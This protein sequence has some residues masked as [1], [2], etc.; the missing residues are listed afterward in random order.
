MQHGHQSCS[1]N[2]AMVLLALP[3]LA[4]PVTPDSLSISSNFPFFH[5][6]NYMQHQHTCR[7]SQELALTSA[8]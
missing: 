6:S 5:Q 7:T 8:E 2:H 4:H 1:A 3:T